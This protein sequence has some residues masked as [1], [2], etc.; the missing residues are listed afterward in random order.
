MSPRVPFLAGGL[1]FLA[2]CAPQCTTATFASAP[3]APTHSVY[4]QALSDYRHGHLAQ[5][6]AEFQRAIRLH[7]NV[8][9]S[10]VGLGSTQ[11][12]RHRYSDAFAA[13]R[14]AYSMRPTDVGLAYSA[15]SAALYA[16]D[17]PDA[18]QF[19]SVYIQRRPH[20]WNGYHLRFEAYDQ[21]ADAKHQIP[22]ATM[23]VKIQPHL[24]QSY[25]D[26]G[27]AYANNR[28]LPQSIQSFTRAIRMQPKNPT[29]YMNRGASEILNNQPLL[30]LHDLEHARK[31]TKDPVILKKIDSTIAQL[32]RVTHQ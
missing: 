1:L 21:N 15:G 31:L 17:F 11:L 16:R 19:A 32:K 4:D 22:D 8:F 3:H 10:Y 14:T 5:A 29:F 18:I 20:D 12:Y 2:A 24:A 28:K 26:L 27:I 30:A 6:A 23:E 7:I 25:S 13:F 9:R